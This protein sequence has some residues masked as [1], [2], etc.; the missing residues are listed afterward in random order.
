M[1]INGFYMH[2]VHY[3]N[4]FPKDI[5]IQL[6]ICYIYF[7]IHNILKLFYRNTYYYHIY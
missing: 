3:A 1:M 6:F 4:V 2:H 5:Q 7:L